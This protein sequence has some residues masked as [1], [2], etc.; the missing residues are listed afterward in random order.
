MKL[1][2]KQKLYLYAELVRF[3]RPIGSYL[4]LWPTLWALAIAGAGSPD[5][6]VLFV[7]VSGVFLMRSAGCAINDY[8]DRNI[9]THVARTKNRPLPS[10]RI[11]TKE[12]LLVFALLC[13]ISFVLVLTLNRY[14]ILLSIAGVLLAAS[15]PF[16]KR[17]HYLPQVHLGAAFG[18]AVP[19]AF[20]AQNGAVPKQGW[21]LYVVAIIWA[22]SYDTMYSMVDREDDLKIGVKSSAILFGEHDRSIIAVFQF[23]FLLAL[24]LIGRDLE[25]G[26]IYNY[27]LLLAAALM[28]YE[29]YLIFYR[30][31]EQCFRAFLHNHWVGAAVFFGI[32]AHYYGA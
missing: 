12:T 4:L 19:M 18:W 29:Q 10:G 24:W 32:I 15:Y 13:I 20:A 1:A 17:F 7:F 16:M 21:L 23:L 5:P 28:A 27:A 8:A 25:F 11:S 30:E 31:P 26:A 9:D 6:W 3:D 22:V 14:T 2:I